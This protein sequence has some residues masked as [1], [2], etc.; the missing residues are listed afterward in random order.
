M[1]DHSWL[2]KT[3]TRL[4]HEVHAAVFDWVLALIAEAGLVKGERTGVDASTMA[5]NAALRY[6]VRRDPVECDR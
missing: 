2:S 1:P 5:A 3:R 4:P 6:I